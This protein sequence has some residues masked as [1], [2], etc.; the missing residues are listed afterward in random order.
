MVATAVP[1]LRSRISGHLL[2]HVHPG[3]FTRRAVTPEDAAAAGRTSRRVPVELAGG[4]GYVERGTYRGTPEV[5]AEV[6]HGYGRVINRW[7]GAH[8]Y[9]QAARFLVEQRADA[10]RWVESERQLAA[11]RD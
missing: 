11:M 6:R 2:D 5:L 9:R 1:Q 8:R 7:R 10:A 3:S 4:R